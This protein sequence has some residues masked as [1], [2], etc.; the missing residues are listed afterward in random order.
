[1]KKIKVLSV[2]AVLAATISLSAFAGSKNVNSD[3]QEGVNVEVTAQGKGSCR[4]GGCPCKAYVRLEG[5]A[6]KCVCGHWDYVHNK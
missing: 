2:L 6:G 1:M 4:H 5:G 3:M